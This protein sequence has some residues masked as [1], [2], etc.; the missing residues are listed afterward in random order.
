MSFYKQLFQESI[1]IVWRYKPLWLC[2]FFAILFSGSVEGDLYY[3]F[4]SKTNNPIANIKQLAGSE[5]FNWGFF[6]H[7][8]ELIFSNFSSS[9]AIFG[10]LLGILLIMLTIIT[11]SVASQMLIIK[12]TLK[13]LSETK[14]MVKYSFRELFIDDFSAI[15]GN[16]LKVVTL[17]IV[18]KIFIF[19][20]FLVVTTPILINMDQPGVIANAFYVILLIILTPIAIV[21]SFYIRY[22]VIALSAGRS[23]LSEALS[24]AWQIIKYNWLLSIETSLM[25]F[26]INIV[27]IFFTLL[28]I[29]GLYILIGYL[30]LFMLQAM[31]EKMFVFMAGFGILILAVLYLAISAIVSSFGVVVWANLYQKIL[32]NETRSRLNG[33]V[34]TILSRLD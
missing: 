34:S 31:S 30:A 2:G 22:A 4:L 15:K 24:K 25:V 3:S 23:T 18:F 7:A 21:G 10:I 8:I 11:L 12:K 20:I 29:S 33:F 5:F 6:N 19:V 16:L 13:S 17:N 9:L 26:I 14:T 1:A 28:I 32:K 27:S